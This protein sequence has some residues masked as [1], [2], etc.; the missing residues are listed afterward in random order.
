MTPSNPARPGEVILVYAT[1][2]G[3]VSPPVASGV[4]ATGPTSVKLA[5]NYSLEAS[6]GSISYA[7]L[8]PGFVGLYQ[9]NIQLPQNQ[10]AGTVQFSLTYNNCQYPPLETLEGNVVSLPVQ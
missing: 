3:P 5:C 7:G 9:L 2:L 4:A 10:T 1:G 8:A 6:T